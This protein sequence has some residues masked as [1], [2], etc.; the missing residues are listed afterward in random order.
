[1]SC[2]QK[3]INELAAATPG[4]SAPQGDVVL[5]KARV[6]PEWNACWNNL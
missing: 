4:L 2:W 6:L 1:M 3:S 5:L